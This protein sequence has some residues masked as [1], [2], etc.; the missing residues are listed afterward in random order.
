[1]G[2]LLL[3]LIWRERAAPFLEDA[4]YDTFMFVLLGLSAAFTYRVAQ[5]YLE[6]APNLGFIAV[7]V[8]L[9]FLSQGPEEK[10]P[11][12]RTGRYRRH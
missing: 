6:F 3:T 1:M 5:L 10:R 11:L 7:L 9:L 2:E 12:F 8:F 4:L